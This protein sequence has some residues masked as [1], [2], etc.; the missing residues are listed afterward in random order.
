MVYVSLTDKIKYTEEEYRRL[1]EAFNDKQI[2]KYLR[3]LHV[4]GSVYHATTETKYGQ[5]SATIIL[6]RKNL[7]AV[8]SGC[9]ESINFIRATLEKIVEDSKLKHE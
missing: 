4:Q 1:A 8:I 5:N 9:S 7:N 6:D 3:I 2:M